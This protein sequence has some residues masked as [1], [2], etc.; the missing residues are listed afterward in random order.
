MARVVLRDKSF[1]HG[2][3]VSIS[4]E[5]CPHNCEYTRPHHARLTV[6]DAYSNNPEKLLRQSAQQAKAIRKGRKY[7]DECNREIIR[8]REDGTL[9][10]R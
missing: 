10:W 1:G 7:R 3:R 6:A 4:H 5:L 9:R 8:R 2:V